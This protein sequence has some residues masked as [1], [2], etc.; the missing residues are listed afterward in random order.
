MVGAHSAELRTDERI[1]IGKAATFRGQ[2]LMELVP[3]MD[4]V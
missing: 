2:L 1:H 4:Q 3:G